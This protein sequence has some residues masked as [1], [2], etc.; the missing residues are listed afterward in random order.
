[1]KCPIYFKEKALVNRGFIIRI[2][3]ISYFSSE[4]REGAAAGAGSALGMLVIL[5]DTLIE[6]EINEIKLAPGHK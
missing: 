4:L 2:Y 5:I 3:F 1:M 6:N